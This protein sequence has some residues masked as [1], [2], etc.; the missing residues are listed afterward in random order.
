MQNGDKASSS[1]ILADW[2]L[3]VK[4]FITLV[5]HVIFCLNFVYLGILTLSSQLYE[6]M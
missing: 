5:P 4:I 6:K 1:I 2:A 3:L